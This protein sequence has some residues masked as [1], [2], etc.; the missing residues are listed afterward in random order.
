MS[1]LHTMADAK[2]QRPVYFFY[3]CYDE[4][5]I[6]F[7]KDLEELGKKLDLKL[8]YVLEKPKSPK[9]FLQGF[10]T[11][12]LLDKNLPENRKELF[13]YICGPLPMIDAMESHLIKLGIPDY[14]V[15]KEKYEMA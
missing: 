11:F 10:I 5:N 6:I 1:M 14:K 8:F 4:E 15:N 3:G 7:K 12:D 2:D 9:K 13:Y